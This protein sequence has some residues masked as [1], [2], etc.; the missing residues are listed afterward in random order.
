MRDESK[1][2]T[3]IANSNFV[4]ASDDTFFLVN[5]PTLAADLLRSVRNITLHLHGTADRSAV[6][7]VYHILE[8]SRTIPTFKLGAFTCA[9]KSSIRAKIWLHETRAWEGSK[10]E[11]LVRLHILLTSILRHVFTIDS[12]G[13]VG[14]GSDQAHLWPMVAEA[15]RSIQRV[16]KMEA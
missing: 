12:D 1:I 11:D 13:H 8:T 7:S 3:G 2:A 5:E 6:R 4:R 10:Q 14:S 16:V 9:R 15:A